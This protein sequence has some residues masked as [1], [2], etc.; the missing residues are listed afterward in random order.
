MSQYYVYINEQQQGPL[1]EKEITE[2]L[3]SGTYEWTDYI[4]DENSKEWVT[5]LQYPLFSAKFKQQKAPSAPPQ[6][7]AKGGIPSTPDEQE[8]FVL[9]GDNRHGP[10]SF[11]EIVNMRQ[12]GKIQSHEY[13]WRQS[14]SGWKKLSEVKEFSADAI[15]DLQNS[16]NNQASEAFFRRR[17]AR[18]QYGAS[19]LVHNQKNVFK[20][21]SIEISEGGAAVVLQTDEFPMSST[22]FLH[23]Q[24]GDGVPPFNAICSV[25]NVSPA[26]NGYFKY[27]LKFTSISQS[28]QQAIRNFAETETKKA[29]RNKA[30]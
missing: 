9:Q 22:M 8:W 13:V 5:F 29:K 6:T 14:M 27:G 17:H 23:F 21:N 10:F 12:S 28:M 1:S 4:Y 20:G 30:A 16:K 11:L 26:A 2:R 7:A 3:S 15:R 19:I 18:V 24:P 25:I